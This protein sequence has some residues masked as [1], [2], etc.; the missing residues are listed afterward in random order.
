MLK[1]LQIAREEIWYHTRQWTFYLVTFG[2]PL[3]FA[4]MGALPRLQ[5]VAQ[6]T[7]F[8]SIETVF[9]V[10]ERV[11]V[12]TG[13]VDYA[14][15]ITVVP[16]DEAKNFRAFVDEPAARQA[17]LQGEIES[18]YVIATDY[19]TS[20]KVVQY[21]PK[22]Q[23]LARTDSPVRTLLH[24]N[25]LKTLDNPTLSA[26]LDKPVTVISHGP[27]APLFS[28]LPTDLDINR[29]VSAGLVVGLFAYTI[30]VGGSLLIRSLQREVKMRVLEILITSTTP[31][32]FIGGKLL[33]LS[34][35][36]LGQISLSLLAALWIYGNNPDGSGPTALPIVALAYSLP[37]LFL[38]F[39]AY[40]GGVM[41][42][43]A[44]WPNSKESSLML[45]L[46]RLT[47]LTPLI[48]VLFIL[49]NLNGWLAITLTL[50]P[51]TAALLMPFR[52]LTIDGVPFWQWAVGL[53]GL[54]GWTIFWLWLSTR[55]FRTRPLLT[56]QPF[57]VVKWLGK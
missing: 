29:L 2:M 25:L 40:G 54:I 30:N 34:M 44:L 47:A 37:Y 10:D 14:H 23:L 12:P 56:Q 9:T 13:Y 41:C 32:Q 53:M 22:P 49:P 18:Y 20:G 8:A 28:F 31:T 50:F 33:G 42:L 24:D 43:A 21:S 17:L 52:L 19:I 5:T 36:A 38:G 16:P 39:L 35:L 57:W 7:P 3:L 55:L 4:A 11:T 15:L 1:L 48:G 51:P 46:A 6:K 26:R 27:P 45:T